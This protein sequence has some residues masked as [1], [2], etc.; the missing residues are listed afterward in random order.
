MNTYLHLNDKQLVVASIKS[1][2]ILIV[3]TLTIPLIGQNDPSQPNTQTILEAFANDYLHD[4]HFT[5][6]WTFGVK[7]D[8]E[9][10]T[11]QA[12]AK[13][14]E[15][16]AEIKVLKGFPEVPT[17]YFATTKWALLD[18]AGGKMN[19]LTGAVKAFSTDYAPFDL[20]VMDG[21]QPDQSFVGKV[22]PLMFH[23][24][25]KGTPEIIPF[26]PQYTRTTHGAQA[27]VFYYQPGFRSGYGVIH[28]G[29]HANEN[30]K[31]QTNEF[32]SLFIIVKGTATARLDG[33]EHEIPS[34]NAIFIPNGMKHEF[35]NEGNEPVEFVLLMF[36]EGA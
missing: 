20:E 26:G 35:M 15:S 6:D 23:F 25:T 29:Q 19:A 11:I 34:G 24:W 10:W 8:E 1:L 12:K 2:I 18:I 5:E 9:K 36:G 21:F 33:V 31:S 13:D 16:A 27:T 30:P 7:V 32:P 3:S 4:K 14:P 22:L 28:P 17:F